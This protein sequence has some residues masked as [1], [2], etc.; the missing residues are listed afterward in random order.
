IGQT[1]QPAE[2]IWRHNTNRVKATRNKGP[3]LLFKIYFFPTRAQAVQLERY[4]KRL[5]SPK[6]LIR[7]VLQHPT[8]IQ[9]LPDNSPSP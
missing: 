4:L 9:N 2:R 3:W 7:F 8:S 5:K 1:N 6:A